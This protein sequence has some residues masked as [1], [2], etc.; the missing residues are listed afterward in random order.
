MGLCKRCYKI[1]PQRIF[2]LINILIDLIYGI[3]HYFVKE[4]ESYLRYVNVGKFTSAAV[5]NS[6][7]LFQINCHCCC[8][9]EIKTQEAQKKSN[10][11]I[12]L[13]KIDGEIKDLQLKNGIL[14]SLVEEV[15]QPSGKYENLIT[16]FKEAENLKKQIEEKINILIA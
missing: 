2:K 14:Q 15:N 13:E 12:M 16:K 7:D 9:L 6:L 10:E 3:F 5:L 11:K 8:G 4:E 1:L